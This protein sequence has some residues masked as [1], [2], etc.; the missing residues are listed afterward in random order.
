MAR[1][2]KLKLPVHQ[3]LVYP[4][5]DTAMDTASYRENADAKPLSKAAMEC[6]ARYANQPS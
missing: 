5:A 6:F 4:V 1:D 3:L 2:Q